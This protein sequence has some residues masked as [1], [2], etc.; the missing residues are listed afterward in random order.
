MSMI[1][2]AP[3][4]IVAQDTTPLDDVDQSIFEAVRGW[5]HWGRH[6]PYD[7]FNQAL[8]GIDQTLTY[9]QLGFHDGVT[10]H[11]FL[12]ASSAI[13]LAGIEYDEQSLRQFS[14]R[15]QFHQASH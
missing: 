9:D 15:H 14:Q 4:I 12:M 5:W 8:V 10:C 7:H 3:L 2:F 6:T 1:A 11:Q 13:T